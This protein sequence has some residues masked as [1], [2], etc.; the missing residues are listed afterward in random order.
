MM[1]F[2]LIRRKIYIVLAVI[3][4]TVVTIYTICDK[5]DSLMAAIDIVSSDDDSVHDHFVAVLRLTRYGPYSK[6]MN[7]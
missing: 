1:I 6:K 5:R 2:G 7:R 3:K 4:E